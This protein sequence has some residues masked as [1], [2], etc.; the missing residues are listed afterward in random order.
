MHRSCSFRR[1]GVQCGG[2]APALGHIHMLHEARDADEFRD[3]GA[4]HGEVSFYLQLFSFVSVDEASVVETKSR[5]ADHHTLCSGCSEEDKVRE[6][7]LDLSF[8]ISSV[9]LRLNPAAGVMADPV[10]SVEKI[11]KIGLKIKEAADTV[12][13]NE[14]ACLE[15]RK[16]VLRYSTMLSQL[17]QRGVMNNSSVMSGALDDL[18]ETLER[19]LKLVMACQEKG[20]ISRFVSAGDLSK[21]LRRVKDNMSEKVMVVLCALQVYNTIVLLTMQDVNNPPSRQPEV[22][23]FNSAKQKF[24]FPICILYCC[25][26]KD[27]IVA[28]TSFHGSSTDDARSE[29]Y[30]EGNNILLESELSSVP[31]V[32]FKRI[33]LSDLKAA[34]HDKNII[35]R[36]GGCTAFKAVLND[37]NMVA[38]KIFPEPKLRCFPMD[39]YDHVSKLEHKNIVKVLGCYYEYEYQSYV[40][41]LLKGSH[42]IEWSILFRIIEG[43]AQAVHYLHEQHIVHM[44]V[45]PGN[46]LLDSDMNPKVTDFDLSMVLDA[47]EFTV[48]LIRGAA[49]FIDPDYLRTSIVSMKNDVYNFGITLLQTVSCMRKTKPRQGYV[50]DDFFHIW[51]R[52][53][54]QAGRVIELFDPSLFDCSQLTEIKRCIDVGFLC[55][56]LHKE[57]RPTMAEVL[58]MLNGRAELPTPKIPAYEEQD[59]EEP[60]PSSDGSSG[61][62]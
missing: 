42:K 40:A 1:R 20:K 31:S 43:I 5:E 10:A 39:I 35:G 22:H 45:K 56:Q 50:L 28:E 49:N 14:E 48:D 26:K 24:R 36:G 59:E 7:L 52:E 8:L 18:A 53:A 60:A 57:D 62:V 37:G 34:I 30:G 44:D 13:H 38:V 16:S 47:D 21:Q 11:V 2:Y 51:A 19:A 61:T 55:I 4:R 15:I 27:T 54:W 25:Q 17:Q 46:I 23:C 32:D 3:E 41:R 9:A 6:V 29:L 33:S 12:R 58:K